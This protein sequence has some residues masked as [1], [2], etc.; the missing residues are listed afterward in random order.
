[1]SLLALIFAVA[2]LLATAMAYRIFRIV[3]ESAVRTAIVIG[4]LTLTWLSTGGI[5]V[6]AL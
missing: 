4:L 6:S 3:G 1:M 5:I 2:S